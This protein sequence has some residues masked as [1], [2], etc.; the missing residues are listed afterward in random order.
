MKDD[1]ILNI[2]NPYHAIRCL[3]PLLD[4]AEIDKIRN[5]INR[6]VRQLVNLG[7]SHFRTARRASGPGSWRQ[8][9]SRAYYACYCISRAVRLAVNGAYT[10][11]PA[12]HKK[13]GNLP[14]GFPSSATWSDFL[15]KFRGDRNIADYDHTDCRKNLEMSDAEYVEQTEK[16]IRQAKGYLKNRG[17]L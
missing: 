5:E 2:G 1:N 16:F 4:P 6:N 8:R 9:V 17:H 13:V 7:N 14:N 11:D 15:I 10:T 12:D 3:E